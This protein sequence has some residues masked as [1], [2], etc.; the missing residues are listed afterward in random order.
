MLD[1][2]ISLTGKAWGRSRICTCMFSMQQALSLCCMVWSV[3]SLDG[4]E[5]KSSFELIDVCS[6]S[7]PIV[8]I[9][10]TTLVPG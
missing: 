6:P 5:L 9:L 1:D 8:D 2:E 10:M 3:L 7:W 4:I